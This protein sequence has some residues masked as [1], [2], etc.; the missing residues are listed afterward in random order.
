MPPK[1]IFDRHSTPAPNPY[2]TINDI[3]VPVRQNIIEL[4][5]GGHVP[6]DRIAAYFSIPVQWVQLLVG[7]PPGSTGH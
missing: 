1:S 6:D 4:A 2:K 3:P 5:L 7:A